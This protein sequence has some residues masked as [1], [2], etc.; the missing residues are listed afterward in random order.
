MKTMRLKLIVMSLYIMCIAMISP[1]ILAKELKLAVGLALPPY[2]IAETKSGM[3]LEIIKT[4]LKAYG[5][6]VVPVFV[7][8]SRV[9]GVMAEGKVDCASPI[10]KNSGVKAFYSD[11][12]IEYQNVAISLAKNKFDI[13]TI[14]DL[15]NKSIIGFQ[16]ATK[17]LGSEYREMAANN[18]RYKEKF[19]QKMQ[20]MYLFN[21]RVQVIVMDINIFK[22]FKK[23]VAMYS[24]V[25]QPIT[26]HELFPKTPYN[27]AFRNRDIRDKF[28][29]G[30][31]TIKA[32]LVY[33]KIVKN[34]TN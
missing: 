9:K 5:Y 24:N 26:I 22:Y 31:R 12:H 2:F 1:T 19:D 23:R 28:N 4:A 10:N 30:L 13:K 29:R 3:E 15:S 33:D 11:S 20:N 18:Y 14:N 17:Y 27:V 6:E 32:T 21:N 7:P 34:Y 8:F 25:A 16:D